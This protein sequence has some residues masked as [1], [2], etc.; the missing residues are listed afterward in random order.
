M[1]TREEIITSM[2]YTWRHDYGLDS[3]PIGEVFGR[4]FGTGFSNALDE[5]SFDH[6]FTDSTPAVGMTDEERQILW[7]QMAQIFDND[8]SPYMMFKTAD[9]QTP[10]WKFW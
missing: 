1:K 10:W 7:N 4:G 2:C 9:T 6:A 5:A 3:T 8:I